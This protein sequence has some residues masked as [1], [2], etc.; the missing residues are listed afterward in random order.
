ML[1]CQNSLY[2]GAKVLQPDKEVV[3]LSGHITRLGKIE[4]PG[5]FDTKKMSSR[6]L[7]ARIIRLEGDKQAYV[8]MSKDRGL[9]FDPNARKVVNILDIPD[10]EKIIYLKEIDSYILVHTKESEN[11]LSKIPRTTGKIAWRIPY[12]FRSE[13]YTGGKH[14][15]WLVTVPAVYSYNDAS[16]WVHDGEYLYYLHS[17]WK[18][19]IKKGDGILFK[20]KIG[21][22]DVKTICKSDGKSQLDT[23][24]GVDKNFMVLRRYRQKTGQDSRWASD[25]PGEVYR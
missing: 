1:F 13:F 23:I 4:F 20:F 11:H 22:T 8:L 25:S 18:G 7:P 21:S 5:F 15:K 12:D 3:K 9:V 10:I 16:N 6:K 14:T 17:K 24:E 2:G 19:F